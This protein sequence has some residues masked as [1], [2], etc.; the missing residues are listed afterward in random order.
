MLALDETQEEQ[1]EC[2]IIGRVGSKEVERLERTQCGTS[3]AVRVG[4]GVGLMVLVWGCVPGVA[5]E[6]PLYEL[7]AWEY[8]AIAWIGDR[9]TD[10]AAFVDEANRAVE[11]VF[12]FWGFDAPEGGEG[13]EA[14]F[15][16]RPNYSVTGGPTQ[17]R[18]KDP[19]T[20]RMWLISPLTWQECNLYP[21]LLVAFPDRASMWGAL[22][23]TSVG[24]LFTS[25]RAA[26]PGAD[27][28]LQFLTGVPRCILVPA[29]DAYGVVA[30][31]VAHWMTALVARECTSLGEL[32]YPSD[33]LN[34]GIAEYT[35]CAVLG[36]DGW[37]RYAASWAVTHTLEDLL[38]APD[39]RPIW[40]SLVAYYVETY[41]RDEL[42]AS[43]G[44][45]GADG[46]RLFPELETGWRTWLGVD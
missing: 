20:G 9:P 6:P 42:L 32:A 44:Q 12:G 45:W 22:G 46:T 25:G 10:W 41:G 31:E 15:E 7:S 13:W 27:P 2:V 26:I 34:E 29:I 30:H 14:P 11:E 35:M 23:T 24:G 16:N 5:A 4:I 40:T 37:R 8:G 3:G 38:E 33:G 43:L 18:K 39:S 17:I 1:G 28:S 36:I 21:V 19:S